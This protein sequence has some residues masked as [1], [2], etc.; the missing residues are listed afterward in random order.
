[1][2]I[3]VVFS[4]TSTATGFEALDIIDDDKLYTLDTELRV[5]DKY[6]SICLMYVLGSQVKECK[7]DAPSLRDFVNPYISP[8]DQAVT[9]SDLFPMSDFMNNQIQLKSGEFLKVLVSAKS[10]TSAKKIV[11]VWFSDGMGKE[12]IN[13]KSTTIKATATMTYTATAWTKQQLVLEQ[14][15]P[16]GMYEI[17]GMRVIADKGAF[18]RLVLQPDVNRPMVPCVSGYEH[19]LD[20]MF[21]QGQFGSFGRFENQVPPKLEI[22]GVAAGSNPEVELDIVKVS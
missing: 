8:V 10:T 19:Y 9:P 20:P 17:I 11:G 12:T 15:I 4:K 16:F 3:G 2:K 14:D 21:R 7:L 22:I 1:M 13:G 6:N 18:A 5:P